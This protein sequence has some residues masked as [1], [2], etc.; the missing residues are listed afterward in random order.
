[1]EATMTNFLREVLRHY[2]D[3]IR[4]QKE[5][6]A[7][8][9]V[10]EEDAK[11]HLEQELKFLMARIEKA[12]QGPRFVV[13][14]KDVQ[15]LMQLDNLNDVLK[16]VNEHQLEATQKQAAAAP[17]S[18]GQ[19]PVQHHE[20]QPGEQI[21]RSDSFSST[22]EIQEVEADADTEVEIPDE[23]T[24]W[25]TPAQEALATGRC[26]S[27]A[28]EDHAARQMPHTTALLLRARSGW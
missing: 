2:R 21:C 25:A 12:L 22:S 13:S 24:D 28:T 9:A 10:P 18:E 3:L 17:H 8:D 4:L 6:K 26:S 14:Q 19:S 7:S 27:Q 11:I 16:K 5:G 15:E 20:L 23:V 1:M